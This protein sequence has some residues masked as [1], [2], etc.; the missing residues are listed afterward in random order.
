MV[1]VEYEN[2][3]NDD[4][5]NHQLEDISQLANR[6]KILAEQLELEQAK[7]KTDDLDEAKRMAT[8]LLYLLNE[9]LGNRHKLFVLEKL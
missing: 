5:I 8:T 3:H 1:F 7:Q 9:R 2:N 4:F 6:T